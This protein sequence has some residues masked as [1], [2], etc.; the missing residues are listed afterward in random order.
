M[1]G[2]GRSD[3]IDLRPETFDKPRISFNRWA[4]WGYKTLYI[5]LVYHFVPCFPL[6]LF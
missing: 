3:F 4:N 2:A 6:S 5:W 1:P